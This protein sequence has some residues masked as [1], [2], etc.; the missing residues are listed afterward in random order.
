MKVMKVLYITTS[1]LRNESA[2]I[3]NISLVNGLIENKVEVDILTLD[4]SKEL[5][6]SFLRNNINEK[7]NIK[8][9]NIKKFNNI[10]TK[11]KSLKNNSKNETLKK[12]WLLK[13]KDILKNILFFP[14]VLCEGIKNSDNINFEKNYDYIISSSDSKTS[15]FIAERV[16]KKNNFNNILWIQI[17]GDPWADDIGLNKLNYFLKKRIE[18]NEKRLLKKA[19]KI[20]YLSDLTAERIKIK[21]PDLK[22]KIFI[23][24]RSYLKEI[25]SKNDGENIICSYTGTI[26]NRN[27]LSILNAVKNYNKVSSK[28]V[29]LNFYGIGNDENISFLG[30]DF[31]NIFPRVSF[32]E[33]LNIYSKSDILLYVDNL[34]NSSQIPGKIYDYF[35]TNK[36]ILALVEGEETKKFLEKFKR[37]DI[38]ENRE[39]KINLS[40]VTRKIG[41]YK[42]KE[43]FSPKNIAK[44]FIQDIKK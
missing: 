33:V 2:S 43:E 42:V 31:V 34:H 30:Y 44:K 14:D 4:Y 29:T 21:Y 36:V 27:I 41:L 1:L 40:E 18:I 3:R 37:A 26:K 16:I 9:I 23:L 15:H 22:N 25:I 17:W 28:K 12:N 20:F 19:D 32:E 5:E 7:I 38:Y 8:K 35:G 13:L 11:L 24:Y 39:E 6:D 10:F